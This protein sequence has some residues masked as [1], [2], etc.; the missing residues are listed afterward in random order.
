MIKFLLISFFAAFSAPAFAV[1][2]CQV[3]GKTVYTDM[4]CAG[5]KI[6]PPHDN[7]S[8]ADTHKSEQEHIQEKKELN[9]L[10]NA[11]H[12]GEIKEDRERQHIAHV[13]N[14]KKKKCAS[15]G[16][17]KKWLDEDAAAAKGK[18]S[19]KAKRKAHRMTEKYQMECGS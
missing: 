15:L 7:P 1:Y 9:R 2:Q 8:S 13:I 4:P 17:R 3:D 5:G 16:L 12:Q 6:L 14:T 10:R 18:T 11:R 19:E